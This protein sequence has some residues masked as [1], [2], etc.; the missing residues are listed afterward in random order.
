[1]CVCVCVCVCV[2][3]CVKNKRCLLSLN[4]NTFSYMLKSDRSNLKLSVKNLFLN[5]AVVM[6]GRKIGVVLI[7]HLLLCPLFN[8]ALDHRIYTR[9]P[10]Y[11]ENIHSINMME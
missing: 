1:M 11:I 6:H 3:L 10:V 8:N 9:M 5:I 4:E 2:Y 7:I